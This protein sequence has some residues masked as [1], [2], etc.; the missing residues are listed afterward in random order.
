[1]SGGV[2]RSESY[3]KFRTVAQHGCVCEVGPRK[4]SNALKAWYV[5]WCVF[6]VIM[7]VFLCDI[8]YFCVDGSDFPSSPS[9]FHGLLR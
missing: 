5:L 9:H 8:S 4:V 3:L 1:M 6:L 2:G 7:H